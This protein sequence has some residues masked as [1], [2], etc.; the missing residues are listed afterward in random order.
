MTARAVDLSIVLVS[1]N[2]AD[3]TVRAFDAVDRATA[4]LAVQTICVDNGSTD[5]TVARARREHP[6][7]HVLQNRAN[8]G[9]G[10]AANR[11]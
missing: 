3:L 6:E 4:P 2:T 7:V 8:L 1:W 10:R 9:F 5:D 11:G